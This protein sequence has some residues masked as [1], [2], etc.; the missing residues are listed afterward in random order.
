MCI[1]YAEGMVVRAQR[2]HASALERQYRRL[3]FCRIER[4]T[5]TL[6]TAV[7]ISACGTHQSTCSHE[8]SK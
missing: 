7:S 5:T 2:S 1:L 4:A 6:A 8:I 3:R